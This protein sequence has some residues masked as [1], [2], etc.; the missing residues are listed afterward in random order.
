MKSVIPPR[1][2][3]I[4]IYGFTMGTGAFTGPRRRR[5]HNRPSPP[6]PQPATFPARD[7][8]RPPSD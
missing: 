3:T 8:P 7:L 5:V 1:K 4:P 2:S 6:T